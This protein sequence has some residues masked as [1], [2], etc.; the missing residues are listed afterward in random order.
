MHS[1]LLNR[2][3]KSARLS[4]LSQ[5]KSAVK[6]LSAENNKCSLKQMEHEECHSLGSLR[7]PCRCAGWA[8]DTRQ[9]VSATPACFPTGCRE[10][11]CFQNESTWMC[12]RCLA[13]SAMT[14]V[15]GMDSVSFANQPVRFGL[16]GRRQNAEEVASS[17]WLRGEGALNSRVLETQSKGTMRVMGRK[18][19]VGIMSLCSNLCFILHSATDPRPCIWPRK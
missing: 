9:Q 11:S 8:P 6:Q 12:V 15:P 5:W 2:K 18:E 4:K 14:R 17:R 10:N 13:S 19:I 3:K 7:R 1:V 16:F